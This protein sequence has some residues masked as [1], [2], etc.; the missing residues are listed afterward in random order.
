MLVALLLAVVVA[1]APAE[2]C[3]AGRFSSSAGTCIDCPA[4]RYQEFAG[5]A[6]CKAC[7]DGKFQ[8]ETART[9]C[10]DCTDCTEAGT[11]NGICFDTGSITGPGVCVTGCAQ[12]RYRLSD[13]TTAA[14][15]CPA[16]A[17]LSDPS[18]AIGDV[19]SAVTVV[20]CARC[21]EGTYQAANANQTRCDRCPTGKFSKVEGAHCSLCPAGKHQAASGR[22]VSRGP[23][24]IR[25]LRPRHD[26]RASHPFLVPWTRTY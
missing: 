23:P 1:L 18:A 20:R 15:R 2:E 5:Q 17:D 13:D 22:C 3:P 4:G 16:D 9:A 24:C 6:G 11:V 12:G 21:E 26:T 8:N 25:C 10:L 7:A 19:C 14:W